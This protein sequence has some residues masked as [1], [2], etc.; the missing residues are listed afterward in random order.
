MTT[1]HETPHQA[2]CCQ[3][4][5][6]TE[7]EKWALLERA[8][9]CAWS[10]YQ[11]E[12]LGPKLVWVKRRLFCRLFRYRDELVRLKESAP[13]SWSPRVR[14]TFEDA[15]YALHEC[16]DPACDVPRWPHD[17]L[18]SVINRRDDAIA[19]ATAKLELVALHLDKIQK[20]FWTRH[21]EIERLK[22]ETVLLRQ[23]VA[24]QR[25]RRWR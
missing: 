19:T 18:I 3:E 2:Q 7:E 9:N 4:P 14:F 12:L 10:R 5:A 20:V 13:E 8:E 1:V 23:V 11:R 22:H 15:S 17:H 6:L 21:R 16:G 24:P 25:Q